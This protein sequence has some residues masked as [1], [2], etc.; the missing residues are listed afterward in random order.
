MR[1]A[2]PGPVEIVPTVRGALFQGTVFFAGGRTV[3]LI[4]EAVGVIGI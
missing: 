3:V 1:W 4:S 2:R